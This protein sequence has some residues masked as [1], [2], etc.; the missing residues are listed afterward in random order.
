MNGQGKSVKGQAVKCQSAALVK[1]SYSQVVSG[2]GSDGFQRVASNKE[3]KEARKVSSLGIRMPEGLKSVEEAP[4]WEAL[5]M[6][7]DSGASESVVS[8]EM[9]TRPTTVEGEAFF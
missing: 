4:E 1:R 5:E 7:V 8:D 9:L 6:A 3:K 2:L